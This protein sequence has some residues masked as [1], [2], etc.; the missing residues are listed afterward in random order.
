MRVEKLPFEEVQA[1]SKLFLDYCTDQNA[2]QPFYAERPTIEGFGS[3]GAGIF[4]PATGK[5]WSGY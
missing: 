3:C 5:P 2:L 4:P 1:F